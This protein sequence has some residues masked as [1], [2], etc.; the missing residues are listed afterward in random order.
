[1]TAVVD[2]KKRWFKH[3]VLLRLVLHMEYFTM[4]LFY[5]LPDLSCRQRSYMI[6]DGHDTELGRQFGG[7]V[8]DHPGKA[9]VFLLQHG[10]DA[11]AARALLTRLAEKSLDIQL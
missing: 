6:D 2:T 8:T 1:M 4:G 10:R 9:G 5:R 7:R 11:F 3:L